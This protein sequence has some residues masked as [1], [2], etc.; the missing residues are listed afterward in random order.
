MSGDDELPEYLRGVTEKSVPSRRRGSTTPPPVMRT[1]GA[2]PTAYDDDDEDFT[3]DRPPFISPLLVIV[4]LLLLMVITVST[5]GSVM[6]GGSLVASAEQVTEQRAIEIAAVVVDE[7]KV[8]DNIGSLGGDR[9]KL[10]GLYDQIDGN[11][12][13]AR[14]LAS[15]KYAHAVEAELVQLGDIRGTPLHDRQEKLVLA[16]RRFEQSLDGWRGASSS[17]LGGAAVTIGMANP[18]PK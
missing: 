18:P 9:V 3:D 15:L 6:L 2:S 1:I 7:V 4:V 5:L 11:Q 16:S 17:I 13:V 8:I 10:Q 14:G 12:G